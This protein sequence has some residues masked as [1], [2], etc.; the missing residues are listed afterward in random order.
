MDTAESTLRSYAEAFGAGDIDA[1][2]A[3]YAER[4]DYRQPFAKVPMTGRAEIADF[5]RGMFSAFSAIELEL[6]W[7]V[8][9]G[10]EAAAGAV[11]R[12]THTGAMPLPDGST[13]PPTNRTIE[14]HT[15]EHVR[16]D[17]SGKILEHQR[18]ADTATL[19]A[20]LGAVS[21]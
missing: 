5:E 3:H 2:V 19:L 11:I 16:V 21:V 12:A 18:Y 14:L 7:V 10:N 13:L 9:D 4:T 20:R 8:G 6:E 15:A 17:G 1:L